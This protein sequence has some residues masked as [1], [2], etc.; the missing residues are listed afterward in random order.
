M[1]VVR[2][3]HMFWNAAGQ[4]LLSVKEVASYLGVSPC[5]VYRWVERQEIP[6]FKRK[7]LGIRFRKEE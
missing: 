5:T 4:R 7:G 2:T 1:E 6:I 3:S